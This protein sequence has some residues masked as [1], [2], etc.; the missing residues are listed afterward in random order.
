MIFYQNRVV[1]STFR[2]VFAGNQRQSIDFE[3]TF[4]FGTQI[5]EYDYSKN[6]QGI[7]VSEKTPNNPISFK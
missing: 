1:N 5:I 4:K 2:I 7:L 3:Y 6:A